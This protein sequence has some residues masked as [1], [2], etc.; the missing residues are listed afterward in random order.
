MGLQT[1]EPE[2]IGYIAKNKILQHQ[3]KRKEL[4]EFELKEAI[5]AG[6]N[7]EDADLVE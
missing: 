4:A 3:K 1:E 2:A 6:A 5:K 7:K